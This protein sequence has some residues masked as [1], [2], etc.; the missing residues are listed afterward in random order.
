[1]LPYTARDVLDS[2]GLR[3]LSVVLDVGIELGKNLLEERAA[4]VK[5]LKRE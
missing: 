2:R 4:I 1:M 3:R 5:F